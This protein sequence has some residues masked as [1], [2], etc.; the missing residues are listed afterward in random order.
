MH[1][2]FTTVHFWAFLACLLAVTIP[3]TQAQ[4]A[5]SAQ[6]TPVITSPADLPFDRIFEEPFLA[7]VRPNVR[8]ISPDA[9]NIYFTWNDSAKADRKTYVV[10][11]SGGIIDTVDAD[12]TLRYRLSPDQSK[13]LYVEDQAVYLASSSMDG[14]RFKNP[15]EII[16]SKSRLSLPQWSPDGSMI[17]WTQDGDIWAMT[18]DNRSI[19]KV[20]DND[21]ADGQALAGWASN[22]HLLLVSRDNEDTRL[23]YFPEYVDTFV[24][25]G[26]SRRG[27]YTST[28]SVMHL[29]STSSKEL[30][31]SQ[32]WVRTQVSPTGSYLALD[33]VDAPMKKRQIHVWDAATEQTSTVF[34]DSTEGWI[35]GRNMAFS[36]SNDRLMFQSE[37]S[38]WNHIYTV[39]PDGSGLRQHTTGS[40]DIPF[41]EWI[42][43]ETIVMATTQKDLGERHVVLL[44][45]RDGTTEQ[46]TEAEG[47]RYQFRLSPDKRHL[48]YA[49]TTFNQPYDLYS[50]DLRRPRDEVQLTQTV[51][52]A[53]SQIDWQKEQYVRFTGRDGETELSM[54]ILTPE[55]FDPGE[56]KQYPTVVFVHGAGSLQNVY[57]GFSNSYYREYM[58]HQ[59]L[60]ARGYVVVEVDYRHSTGY[61]RKFREDVTNWMGKYETQDIIDGL[62]W[63]AE[64]GD[65][66][67]RDRVGIYGGSYGGFMALYATTVAPDHFHA[68]A[69]LRA[70]TNWR[71]YYYANPWY[72]MPR[73]GTPEENPLHYERS[74]PLD[75][76]DDL[77]RPVLILHGLVDDNVGFQDAAQYIEALIQAGDKEFDM[78]MYPSEPHGFQDPDSWI[79]EYERIFEFFEEKL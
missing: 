13:V 45:L 35:Y 63:I 21:S 25:P 55:G 23:V 38:G 78:M 59:W 71:N 32:G 76:V 8:T 14:H 58:F 57:K 64:N 41:A 50:L 74:S 60:T 61:G 2:F 7:G 28:Y 48:V 79:D 6:D 54:S 3:H 39:S 62:D 5:V 52:E 65:Y 12:A 22:E 43:D 24:E 37:Q 33:A 15:E 31:S 44:D 16:A 77:E 27:L 40:Y 72:T 70:V 18:M 4:V 67:D 73:L 68:A 1:R 20:L 46:L 10:E 42:D 34:E 26:E 19:Q 29:D 49:Y 36:P 9:Q 53:F 66:V 56:D 17:A 11:S 75:I 51:P 69:A 47:Y 30:L